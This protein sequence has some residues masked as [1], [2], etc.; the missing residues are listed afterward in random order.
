MNTDLWK[1]DGRAGNI[2]LAVPLLAYGVSYLYLAWYHAT[3]NLFTTIVHEGGKITLFGSMFYASH[4][5]GHVPV[6]T[7]AALLFAGS[8]LCLSGPSAHP[9]FSKHSRGRLMLAFGLFM[10]FS[11]VVSIIF[12]GVEDTLAFILQQKQSE[13]V[14][15]QGGS[16]SL[17]LPSSALLF[18][19]VPVYI[20][21]AFALTGKRIKPSA[22]GVV[23]IVT[24]ALFFL[25]MNLLVSGSII[26]ETEKIWTAPR[27][28][29]HSVRELMT[30]PVTYFTLPLYFF[31]AAGADAKPDKV[32]HSR[33]LLLFI[34]AA[35]VLF[36]A[37]VGYQSAVSLNAGISDIAQKP[38]FAKGG[39]LGI[40]YLLA[41]HY[42]EHLLDTVYFSLLT[43]LLYGAAIGRNRGR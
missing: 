27:Y 25:I 16:W 33:K 15:G 5:L 7:M 32:K 2:V 42:F 28:M 41:S 37:G 3:L 13:T 35:S 26:G 11:T 6:Y 12:F 43:V 14:Y 20:F 39:R 19:L 10:V 24:A 40:P 31:L 1:R 34:G 21:F 9:V 18:P 8:A 4:F 23:Y 30:F 22:A 17:H 36:L 38:G 29:A